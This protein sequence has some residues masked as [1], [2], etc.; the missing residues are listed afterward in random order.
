MATR[1]TRRRGAG[2]GGRAAGEGGNSG[3]MAAGGH[4]PEEGPQPPRGWRRRPQR[5]ARPPARG[6]KH[7]LERLD[8][9]DF[10][11]LGRVAKPWLAVVV[12]NNLPRA[13]KGGAVPLKLKYFVGS[14]EMLAWAKDNGCPWKDGTCALLAEHGNLTVLQWARDHDCSWDER[15]CALRR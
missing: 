13:G 3:A 5:A 12:A 1:S 7:V 10:A 14:V 11:V 8:V 9:T 4:L 6:V 15:T 2:G